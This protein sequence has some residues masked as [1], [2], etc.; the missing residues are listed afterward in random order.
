MSV[1]KSLENVAAYLE[2]AARSE[3][4]RRKAAGGTNAMPAPTPE[5]LA[6]LGAA[7]SGPPLRALTS[8]TA[9]PVETLLP[10]VEGLR[11]RS[12]VTVLTDDSGEKSLRAT[13]QGVEL[14]RRVAGPG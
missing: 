6:V 14:L 13:V 10:V 12:L 5:E 2:H 3:E 4:T 7:Q 9:L 11:G 1:V 8:L